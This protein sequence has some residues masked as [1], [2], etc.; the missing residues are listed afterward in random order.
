MTRARNRRNRKTK[1]WTVAPE[2]EV[3]KN[4]TDGRNVINA[5]LP[6]T[7]KKP[8]WSQIRKT[9]GGTEP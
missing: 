3:R 6:A 9:V 5:E 4:R 7:K 8:K 1:A 2:P